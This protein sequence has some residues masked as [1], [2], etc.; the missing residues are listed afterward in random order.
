M[1]SVSQSQHRLMAAACT[2]SSSAVPKQTACEFMHADS[3]K[4][5]GLPER[6]SGSKTQRKRQMRKTK[7]MKSGY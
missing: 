2:G 1:P 6:K 5:K 7:P 3:G 4:T